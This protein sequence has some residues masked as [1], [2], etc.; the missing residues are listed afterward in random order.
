MYAMLKYYYD[1]MEREQNYVDHEECLTYMK[2]EILKYEMEKRHRKYHLILTR[3]LKKPTRTSL[4][5][6]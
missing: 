4:P 5:T 3:M 6:L 1:L 2:N